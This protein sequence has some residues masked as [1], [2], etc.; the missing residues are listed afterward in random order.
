MYIRYT[1]N[2]NRA[3]ND[4]AAAQRLFEIKIP[5]SL[6]HGMNYSLS[7]EIYA[8]IPRFNGINLFLGIR[9]EIFSVID[10]IIW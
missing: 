5:L 8:D 6:C 2:K 10:G 3:E 7:K 9:L 1:C 4:T